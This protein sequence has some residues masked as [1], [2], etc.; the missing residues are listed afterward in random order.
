M[1][2]L[3]VNYNNL[4]KLICS[5]IKMFLEK[6]HDFPTTDTTY[7]SML[8]DFIYNFYFYRVIKNNVYLNNQFLC[9][10]NMHAG[11]QYNYVQVNL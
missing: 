4:K 9:I 6:Y 2:L 1:Y 7:K 8:M 5:L 11:Y 3:I 10:L